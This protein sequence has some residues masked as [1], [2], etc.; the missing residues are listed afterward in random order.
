MLP[1]ARA[2]TDA[3]HEVA[4]AT[5]EAIGPQV[6]KAGFELM[7]AGISLPDQLAEARRRFPDEAALVGGERFE[8]FVPR[9]LGEVAAPARADDLMP[10][11]ERWKPDVLVHDE[12]EFAGAIA[13]VRA[14]VPHVTQSVGILRPFSMARLTRRGLEPVYRRWGVSLGPY[15]GLFDYLYLDVCPPTLQ[16]PWIDEVDVAR[17]VQN[18]AIPPGPGEKPPAWL[19]G[20]ADRPTV[21]V[22]L[23]TVFNTDPTVLRT[24]VEGAREEPVNV[25]V[26][27]G[28]DNDPGDLGPQPDSV[29]VERYVSQALLLPHCDVVI[30]QGGTAILS[31]LAEGLP[32]MVVPQGANQFHNAAALVGAGAA[33]S[34]LPGEVTAES[35]RAELR[36]LLG[37]PVYRERAAG[38]AAELAA[39]P[40]PET[41]VG[42]VE[43]VSEERVPVVAS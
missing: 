39:M 7:P 26:T 11:V 42:L 35:V 22:S 41:G 37:D 2:L 43:R 9:M 38:I 31:I 34:L 29:H 33:R 16:S 14:G 3:G 28:R 13:A 30:N 18:V 8:N 5:A 4:F 20:L 17:P 27:V 1:L 6:A 25:I 36:T 23:G 15:G 10:I 21:Y 32:V 12:T 40:G 19:G 24:I